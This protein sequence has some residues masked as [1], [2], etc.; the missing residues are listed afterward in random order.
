MVVLIKNKD[1]GMK[2]ACI[3]TLIS[4]VIKT[5]QSNLKGDLGNISFQLY[6]RKLLAYY[7][8]QY[9][10]SGKRAEWYLQGQRS[11]VRDWLKGKFCSFSIMF[12]VAGFHCLYPES[13]VL[14][15]MQKGQ[16]QNK[17]RRYMEVRCQS[18]GDFCCMHRLTTL[19]HQGRSITKKQKKKGRK[20]EQ[21]HD[22]KGEWIIPQWLWVIG[23]HRLLPRLF[24]FL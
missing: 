18:S 9:G 14:S 6:K 4:S 7:F 21:L 24:P 3:Y 10:Y 5:V 23:N 2:N 19:L 1:S 13:T 22:Q 8:W 17:G 20:T 11:T 15:G 16:W 12:W